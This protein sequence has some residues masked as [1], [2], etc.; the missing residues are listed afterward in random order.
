MKKRELRSEIEKPLSPDGEGGGTSIGA[1]FFC[2]FRAS[3]RFF[4]A[5]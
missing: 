4:N 3:S 5:M 1:F 2:F